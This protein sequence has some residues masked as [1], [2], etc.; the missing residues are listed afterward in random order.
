MSPGIKFQRDQMRQRNE[1]KKASRSHAQGRCPHRF[2]NHGGKSISKANDLNEPE[3]AAHI[4]YSTERIIPTGFAQLDGISLGFQKVG[5]RAELDRIR[6]DSQIE[7]L[8]L[9]DIAVC[10]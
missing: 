9:A 2:I 1:L 5:Q 8:G 4:D 3:R 10:R 7:V 6:I